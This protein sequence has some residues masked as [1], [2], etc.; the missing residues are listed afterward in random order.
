MK[1][2]ILILSILLLFSCKEDQK[3]QKVKADLENTEMLEAV[4]APD[5]ASYKTEEIEET[6]STAVYFDT[7][8]VFISDFKSN[9]DA[10]I[11]KAEE[12]TVYVIDDSDGWGMSDKK[13]QIVANNQNWK[14][15]VE[16]CFEEKLRV[17]KDG[18]IVWKGNSSYKKLSKID[19]HNFLLPDFSKEFYDRCQKELRDTLVTQ[20]PEI[21]RRLLDGKPT[22]LNPTFLIL[23]IKLT[24]EKG[25]K[26]NSF[27]KIEIYERGC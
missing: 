27:I 2:T 16:Y 5:A 11:H 26:M 22:F 23:K 12:N 9:T 8:T 17:Q 14:F 10:N 18:S 1:K 25:N 7:F 3:V 4:S 19:N 20:E 13:L 15:D 21:T 24:D 6:P